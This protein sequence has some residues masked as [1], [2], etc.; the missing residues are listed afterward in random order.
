MST[1]D[2]QSEKTEEQCS[3]NMFND[4]GRPQAEA[5]C[6]VLKVN[7]S[8]QKME[9]DTRVSVSLIRQ[10]T[11]TVQ[12]GGVPE[13]KQTNVRKT[14]TRECTLA[15]AI[16]GDIER[17]IQRAKGTPLV[18]LERLQQSGVIEPVEFLDWASLKCQW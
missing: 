4:S 11:H 5:I 13:L 1:H 9:V 10:G 8:E 14:C 18:E 15:G 7:N 2:L 16:E 17:P 6:S 3:F 12:R